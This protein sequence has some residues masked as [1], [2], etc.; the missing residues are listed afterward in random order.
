MNGCDARQLLLGGPVIAVMLYSG[1]RIRARVL[2]GPYALS[3][4]STQG[5][6]NS[7]WPR[8]L[9]SLRTLKTMR[10]PIGA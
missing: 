1:N 5:N 7:E 6:G 8:E 3:T 10:M 9:R 2:W 4:R